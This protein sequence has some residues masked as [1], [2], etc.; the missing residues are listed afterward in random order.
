MQWKHNFLHYLTILCSRVPCDKCWLDTPLF[1]IY[2]SQ[3]FYLFLP[4]PVCRSF[5]S[6]KCICCSAS[7]CPSCFFIAGQEHYPSGG[8]PVDPFYLCLLQGFWHY[9][10]GFYYCPYKSS[11]CFCNLFSKWNAS[12]ESVKKQYCLCRLV[13]LTSTL[14][15]QQHCCPLLIIPQVHLRILYVWV[16]DSARMNNF[17]F[18][19]LDS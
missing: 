16:L 7:T 15:P 9:F 11:V 14:L 6:G 1:C 4:L 13:V 17:V 12:I 18:Y 3:Q 10:S 5:P 2:Y 8:T 19:F